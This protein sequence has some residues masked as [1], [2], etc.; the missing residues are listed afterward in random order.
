MLPDKD[1]YKP[2]KSVPVNSIRESLHQLLLEGIQL[3]VLD[4]RQKRISFGVFSYVPYFPCLSKKAQKHFP[5]HMRP[6]ISGVGSITERLCVWL[7]NLLQP[8]VLRMP[9]HIK[10]MKELL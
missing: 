8:L 7:D 9:G 4:N 10:D 3:G 5:S 2:L 1:T 6:I